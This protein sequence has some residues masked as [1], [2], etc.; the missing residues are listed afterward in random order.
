M[1]IE[2]NVVF[3]QIIVWLQCVL[4]PTILLDFVNQQINDSAGF[5]VC[6]SNAVSVI[7]T[8]IMS[9]CAQG[10]GCL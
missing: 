5:I 6:K 4:D 1:V 8:Y 2:L 9:L 3:Y 10:N 7:G